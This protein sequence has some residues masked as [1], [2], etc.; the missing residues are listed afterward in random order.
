MVSRHKIIWNSL[1]YESWPYLNISWLSFSVLLQIFGSGF[2]SIGDDEIAV[3]R[4][5]LW[6]EHLVVT[7]SLAH[8]HLAGTS[9]RPDRLQ[10]MEEAVFSSL[11]LVQVLI[12]LVLLFAEAGPSCFSLGKVFL[13]EVLLGNFVV[14][15]LYLRIFLPLRSVTIVRLD[16]VDLS[17]CC[18][19][20]EIS[21]LRTMWWFESVCFTDVLS[22]GCCLVGADD[23]WG[24]DFC[25]KHFA[26]KDILM[27]PF[28]PSRAL[29]QLHIR[30][31][32][33]RSFLYF[34]AAYNC[35]LELKM[36]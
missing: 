27:W 31:H 35:R 19:F 20:N 1:I 2:G 9:L 8:A 13:I 21:L 18:L 12:W 22:V 15:C 28:H 36:T 26:R 25:G 10:L 6:I 23:N 24:P 5:L 14:V 32:Y 7:E 17:W 33:W 34:I 16:R 30:F 4:T 29:K 3:L 11:F